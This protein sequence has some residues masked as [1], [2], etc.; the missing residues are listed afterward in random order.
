[1]VTQLPPATRDTAADHLD[2]RLLAL[3]ALCELVATG[4]PM[5][6]SGTMTVALDPAGGG[7]ALLRAAE[8]IAAEFDVE[9]RVGIA[10]GRGTIRIS[11]H[12]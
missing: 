1:M 7:T 8:Q 3:R 11:Q 10:G 6:R 4:G 2:A 9:E 5:T 12:R